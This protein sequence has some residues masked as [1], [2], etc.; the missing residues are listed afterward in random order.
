MIS[1]V[2]GILVWQLDPSLQNAVAANRRNFLDFYSAG[3]A[4]YNGDRALWT[5]IIT[6]VLA[7]DAHD[8]DY[9]WITGGR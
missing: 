8:P 9:L 5:K 3:L 2:C 1:D 7:R 4:A 6:R